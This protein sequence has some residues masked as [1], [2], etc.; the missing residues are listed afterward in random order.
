M[1]EWM[2]QKEGILTA[3]TINSNGHQRAVIIIILTTTTRTSAS[4]GGHINPFTKTSYYLCFLLNL[5]YKCICNINI[6]NKKNV[7]VILLITVYTNQRTIHSPQ[8]EII[9]INDYSIYVWYGIYYVLCLN[10]FAS[11]GK[12]WFRFWDHLLSTTCCTVQTIILTVF[13]STALFCSTR[14]YQWQWLTLCRDTNHEFIPYWPHRNGRKISSP[15]E[16]LSGGMMLDAN[17]THLSHTHTIYI[18]HAS[19]YHMYV[20]DHTCSM[21]IYDDD[22]SN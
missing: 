8:F 2:I 21:V 20:S 12:L 18:I 19:L 3:Y 9:L 14:N 10:S 16:A 4:A 22:S 17:W 15:L 13:S 5:K 7:I 1:N 11:D 6:K